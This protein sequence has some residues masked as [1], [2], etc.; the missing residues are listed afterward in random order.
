MRLCAP[1]CDFLHPTLSSTSS[2]PTHGR[3]YRIMPGS[4]VTSSPPMNQDFPLPS[5]AALVFCDHAAFRLLQAFD[6][7]FAARGCVWCWPRRHRLSMFLSIICSHESLPSSILFTF[8]KPLHRRNCILNGRRWA[9]IS[10]S[11]E[12]PCRSSICRCACAAC[13]TST[14][15]SC[16]GPPRPC[17]PSL[18]YRKCTTN[19]SIDGTAGSDSNVVFALTRTEDVFVWG[20]SGGPCG[21]RGSSPHTPVYINPE[22]RGLPATLWPSKKCNGCED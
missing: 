18:S 10:S 1:T 14:I 2:E 17:R 21:L 3:F 22:V 13:H 20:A 9:R 6:A 16:P 11:L 4:C 12:R 8:F 15:S 19:A 5:S 7:S